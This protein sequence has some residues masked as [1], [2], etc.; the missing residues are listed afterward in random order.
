MKKRLPK[1]VLMFCVTFFL[2][3]CG[4]ASAQNPWPQVTFTPATSSTYD[5]DV[6]L[7]ITSP[8]QGEL[9][10]VHKA[11][12]TCPTYIEFDAT[13]VDFELG[14][15]TDGNFPC[16]P[17]AFRLGDTIGWKGEGQHIYV[18][19][20]N[21]E[22]RAITDLNVPTYLEVP[23]PTSGPHTLRAY[24]CRSWDESLKT[25]VVPD[26]VTDLYVARTFYITSNT[27]T[28]AIDTTKPLL[29][30]NSPLDTNNYVYTIDSVL[31]DFYLM[32]KGVSHGYKVEVSI[33]DSSMV[34]LGC[35][36][37]TQWVPHCISG[38]EQPPV[39]RLRKYIM[40]T[41]LLDSSDNPV[42]NGP[43]NFNN[44]EWAFWVRRS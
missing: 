29:T 28:H 41:R 19:V 21:A 15:K 10:T 14:E 34:S 25:S 1:V 4:R 42:S 9:V 6:S 24:L 40:K 18:V 12:D 11:C 31:F 7:D 16:D 13:L 44:K 38:L 30:P 35:D 2:S 8:A 43:G 27:G 33:F 17:P 20:D 39:G 26:R 32:F 3:L 36:T 22:G 37:I 23:N 5:E